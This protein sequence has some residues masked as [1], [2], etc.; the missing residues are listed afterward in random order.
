[1]EIITFIIYASI[2]I[3][4]VATTF[5]ILTYTA[6]RKK[7]L[8]FS[9]DELPMVSILIPAYNE[10]KSIKRTI[11]SI[12]KSDYPKSKFE[13]IVINNNSQDRTLEVAK[14]L[15]K[16]NR[17]LR[18]FTEMKQGKGCALNLG[19]SKAKGEIIFTMDADTSVHPQ[20]MKK[21]TRYFK[22]PEIYSVTPG[23]VIDKPKNLLQRI[24]YTEYLLGL[25]LR[26]TFSLLNAI[27]ITPGAFSAYRAEF[28]KKY[29]GYDENNITEDLEISLRIQFNGHKI[30][31]VPDA[32]AYTI[33]P[34]KFSH[35]LNQRKRWY[36]GLIKN[37]WRYRR[38]ISLK[39]GDMGI[40]VMPI[41]WISILFAVVITGY[42]FI[43]T[44][45]NVKDELLFLQNINYDFSNFLSLN[46]FFFERLFFRLAT[47][48]MLIFILMFITVLG[49]YLYYARKKVG[50]LHTPFFNLILFFI[51]FAVLF[52]FWWV[53]SIVYV[54]FNRE[55]KWK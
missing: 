25:F 17:Q 35:L 54:L 36:I 38:L 15:S 28:F 13:V 21:M 10:E 19:I 6:S 52:G 45:I 4:L 42:L 44:L 39:Y 22:E 49:I 11:N 43:D 12:L 37:T 47:N 48:T 14:N 32:P 53:V 41:A 46:Y 33:A 3:G 34:N 30:A 18:V 27:Y 24:Q 31:N 50:R 29:G 20:T 9:D 8:L 7:E 2:Y 1:M 26:K 16:S 23:M 40:F 5:Y 55:I 51:F